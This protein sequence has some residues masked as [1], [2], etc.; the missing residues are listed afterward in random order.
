MNDLHHGAGKYT[1]ANGDTYEGNWE[2]DLRNGLGTY[3]YNQTGVQVCRG[4]I[5]CAF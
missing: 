5:V 2:N 4:H 1:Y 3:T